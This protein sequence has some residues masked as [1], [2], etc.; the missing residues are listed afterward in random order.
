M[1]KIF[2]R[3]A[4]VF[5]LLVIITFWLSHVKDNNKVDK[6]LNDAVKKLVG[7]VIR[8]QYKTHDEEALKE[9]CTEELLE[10]IEDYYY[11]FYRHEL[12][13]FINSNYMQT[14]RYSEYSNKWH[15]TLRVRE[16]IF[17]GESFYLYIGFT[18]QE[19]GSYLISSI[20]RGR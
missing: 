11:K 15:V 18:Q 5:I 14:L 13:Y 1:Q 6:E 7:E 3:L 10:N 4:A 12:F 17:S 16:G 8:V 20:G 19:D 2:S 9:I